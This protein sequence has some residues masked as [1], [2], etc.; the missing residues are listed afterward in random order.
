MAV[1]RAAKGYIA[2]TPAHPIPNSLSFLI[3]T[4]APALQHHGLCGLW[5]WGN[6][7]PTLGHAA[8][9]PTGVLTWPTAA[10]RS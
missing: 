2:C 9:S 6:L 10:S 8:A 4:G 1:L 5:G 3:L 7:L